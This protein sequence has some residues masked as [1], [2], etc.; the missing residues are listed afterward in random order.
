MEMLKPRQSWRN[1]E[2]ANLS[3][4]RLN[5]GYR[6][7]LHEK[8][9]VNVARWSNGHHFQLKTDQVPFLPYEQ[10]SEMRL[11]VELQPTQSPSILA[12]IQ[13]LGDDC[14]LPWHDKQLE[15]GEEI[16]V[17]LPLHIV[18][19]GQHLEVRLHGQLTALNRPIHTIERPRT[20]T[21]EPV[22]PIE[23]LGVSPSS[24]TLARWFA[25]LELL[26][27]STAGSQE[28][29]SSVA[30]A[31]TN[32]GGMTAGL[33]ILREHDDW[34]T[35]GSHL[36]DP[37]LG[38]SYCYDLLERVLE[39]GRTHY[40][41]A[42][43]DADH[44]PPGTD[45]VVAA[46]VLDN[47]G[48]V[49]GVVYG[50]RSTRNRN[51]RRS[52]RALEALWMQM[53]AGSM[54][55]ALSRLKAETEAA[56]QAVLLEQAFSPKVV[57]EIT[58]NPAALAGQERETTILFADLRD[59]TRISETLS[60]EENYEL[61]GHLLDRLT[62]EV[63]NC[64]GVIIDY[65]GDGLAAMWNAP[66]TQPDHARLACRAALAMQ[67][68][69]DSLNEVWQHRIGQSIRVGIGINTGTSRVGN[70]GSQTRLKYGPRGTAVVVASRLESATKHLGRPILITEPVVNELGENAVVQRV[71][72]VRLAGITQPVN[73]FE[74]HSLDRPVAPEELLQQICEYELAL[75]HFENGDLDAAESIV[76]GCAC[77]NKKRDSAGSLLKQLIQAYRD[78]P[79]PTANRNQPFVFDLSGGG[80]SHG[81]SPYS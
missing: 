39:D 66:T 28:F 38:I 32:P 72:R 50:Y 11:S 80:P 34:V 7:H 40:H 54:S 36:P 44:L 77:G 10:G 61:L 42:S 57:R 5:R 30:R 49:Q 78:A 56:R 60:A 51:K 2:V 17:A 70:A 71:C 3:L 65:Y 8:P 19:D 35:V 41:D 48:K 63:R 25:T 45:S 79:H 12:R 23:R 81:P 27:H 52:I 21:G 68:A 31:A 67:Q 6:M 24:A 16:D 59:S 64:D 4:G 46:P 75:E 55:A 15:L 26:Q 33:V 22:V 69:V 14:Y 73:A 37:T 20:N 43:E 62:L 47:D 29:F 18:Q 13:N 53:L 9:V 58:E 76:N 74:L 1:A